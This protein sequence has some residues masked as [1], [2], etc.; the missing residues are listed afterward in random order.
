MTA[1]RPP[2]QDGFT[3]LRVSRQRKWQMRRAAECLCVVCGAEAERGTQHCATHLEANKVRSRERYWSH[4]R[5]ARK[6]YALNRD[7]I[8]L[9]RRKDWAAKRDAEMSE[10]QTDMHNVGKVAR[11]LRES[12][13]LRRV[14]PMP[15]RDAGA[16]RGIGRVTLRELVA[17]GHVLPEGAQ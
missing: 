7:R 16:L 1:G 12:A 4:R 6:Y 10:V 17:R 8:L 13:A 14:L 3:R 15:H 11:F 5:D 2:I 9:Q